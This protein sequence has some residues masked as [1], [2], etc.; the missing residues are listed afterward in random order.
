MDT[1]DRKK[2]RLV[3]KNTKQRLLKK[4]ALQEQRVA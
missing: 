4:S 2:K 1:P 3:D